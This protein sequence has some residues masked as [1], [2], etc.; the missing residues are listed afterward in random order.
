MIAP[1]EQL[2]PEVAA[3]CGR[4]GVRSLEVFG[5]AA[6][7]SF[8]PVHSDIDFLVDFCEDEAGSLFHRYFGLQQALEHLFGCKIDL[9]S[10]S[11]ISN[12]YFLA[13]VNQSRQSV[14]ASTRAQAA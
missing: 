5:S 13:T 11:A 14:Y 6:D 10:A 12:P 2:R 1:I 7:G 3:L 9:V 8:D 4:F